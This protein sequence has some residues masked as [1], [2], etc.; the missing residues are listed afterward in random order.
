M[1]TSNP[2]P[3]FALIGV[4]VGFLLGEGSRYVRYRFEIRRN[5]RVILTELKS[6]LAQIPQKQDILNQAIINMKH[7][8]FMPLLSVRIISFGYYSM[9][10]SLY[11]HLKPKERTC[12]HVIFERLR[13]ADEQMD[14][15]E[16][17]FTSIL[18]NGTITNPWGVFIGRCEELLA[19]YRIVIELAISYLSGKPNDIFPIENARQIA[20][21][22]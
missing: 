7:E 11:P 9:L 22:T 6:I 17:I 20:I 1:I 21:M 12:L 8:R 5:K 3:W 10:E 16:E 15:M 4:V 2:S 13:V 18:K 19:S 14:K